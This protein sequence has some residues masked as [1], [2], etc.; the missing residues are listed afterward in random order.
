MGKAGWTLEDM[1]DQNDRTVIVTGGNSGLGFE[2]V[3]GFACKGATVILA[4]RSAEK[5]HAAIHRIHAELPGAK[6]SFAPLDLASLSSVSHF[7][8]EIGARFER[9]DT[10]CNN[11]GVMALPYSLTADGF[12]MQI[13]TNHM[14][15]FALTGQLLPLLARSDAPRI[16]QVGSNSHWFGRLDLTDLEAKR[17]YGKWTAYARSKLAN[18]LFHFE[19]SRRLSRSGLRAIALASHPG[20]AATDLLMDKNNES[21]QSLRERLFI[22]GN[23]LLA[24]TAAEGALPTLYAASE[25]SM[26]NGESVGPSGFG[27]MRGGP[28]KYTPIK[29]AQDV[30][31]AGALWE[32]SVERTGVDFAAL[33][34]LQEDSSC[35]P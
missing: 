3:R 27:Q 22:L 4:C 5:A 23:R 8:G 21:G 2:T 15:H 26:I 35:S 34:N 18:V 28:L 1:T 32:K 25:P 12:E 10:L 6:L 30:S 31:L 16:I 14:G 33:K 24:Q 20:Y 19:L 11:A 29:K 13:G 9:I 7:I 17:R